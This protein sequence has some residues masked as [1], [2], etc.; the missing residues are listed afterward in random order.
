MQNYDALMPGEHQT[1]LHLCGSRAFR[2]SMGGGKGGPV[3]RI[4]QVQ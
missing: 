4:D 3:E 2:R 1:E